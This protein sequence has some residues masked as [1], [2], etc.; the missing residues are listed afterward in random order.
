M[1]NFYKNKKKLHFKNFEMKIIY[2]SSLIFPQ[3]SMIKI[4]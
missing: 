1:Y 4:Q 2:K 3:F